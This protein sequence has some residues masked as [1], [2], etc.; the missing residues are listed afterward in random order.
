MQMDDARITATITLNS[1]GQSTDSNQNGIT[2]QSI[3]I[4]MLYL[5]YAA[6]CYTHEIVISGARGRLMADKDGLHSYIDGKRGT[7]VNESELS[8]THV[9][10]VI[11]FPYTHLPVFSRA[12]ALVSEIQHVQIVTCKMHACCSF[13][14]RWPLFDTR[15]THK[16]DTR[17]NNNVHNSLITLIWMIVYMQM[18]LLT[19]SEGRQLPATGFMSATKSLPFTFAL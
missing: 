4:Q 17:G 11:D 12:Y 8:S 5:E 16:Q 6:N 2:Y 3:Q 9:A 14:N 19:P 18:R 10:P 7:V 13:S 1:V 15:R